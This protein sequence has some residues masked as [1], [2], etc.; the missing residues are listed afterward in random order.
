MSDFY[1]LKFQNENNCVQGLLTYLAQ[2][3]IDFDRVEQQAR[4]F[5]E[6]I[7]ARKGDLKGFNALMQSYDLTS[8]EGLALMTLAEA[9]LRIPDTATANAL[10]NDKFIIFFNFQII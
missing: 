9:L 10:I 2:A 1:T 5:I 8:E 3:N 4:V 7:R 6:T